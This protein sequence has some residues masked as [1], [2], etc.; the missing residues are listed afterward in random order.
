V[1]SGVIGQH[2]ERPDE[3]V[4]AVVADVGHVLQQDRSEWVLAVGWATGVPAVLPDLAGWNRLGWVEPDVGPVVLGDV[5]GHKVGVQRHLPG[6]G[7]IRFI[8]GYLRR[9]GFDAEA[10]GEAVLE[11]DDHLIALLAPEHQRL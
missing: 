10:V 9:K 2:H 5:V 1:R 8:Q 7:A 3:S 11:L 6:H 4:V